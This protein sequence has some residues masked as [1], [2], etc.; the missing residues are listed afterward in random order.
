MLLLL[1]GGLGFALGIVIRIQKDGE[2]YQ[3]TVPASSQTTIDEKGNATVDVT[4]GPGSARPAADET[5]QIET[6][7]IAGA[8]PQTVLSVLT[9]MFTGTPNLRLTVDPKS[10]QLVAMATPAQHAGIRAILE[11]LLPPPGK[12]EA[13]TSTAKKPER[14]QTLVVSP[15]VELKALQGTWNIVRV[16]KGDAAD[17]AWGPFMENYLR[18]G[19]R[20]IF[21]GAAL[22]IR[23]AGQPGYSVYECSVGSNAVPRWIDLYQSVL[24][25]A[26]PFA[27]GVY[28]I[29]GNRL[30]LCLAIKSFRSPR[31]GQRPEELA[32][33]PSSGN[34]LL[35]L[36]R[37]QPSADEEDIQ[38]HWT[39]VTAVEDGETIPEYTGPEFQFSEYDVFNMR[40]VKQNSIA[41]MQGGYILDPGMQPKTITIHTT[42]DGSKSREIFGI[43]KFENDRLHFAYHQGGPRPEKF[44]STRGSGVMLLVLKRIGSAKFTRRAVAPTNP[45]IPTS[46][47][48]VPGAPKA[49]HSA[50]AA[51][52]TVTVS[53]PVVREI[54]DYEDFT[55]R[56]EAAQTVTVRARVTGRLD[57]VVFKPDSMVKQGD[58]LFEIDP[59]P[60]QAEHDKRE[61]DVRLAQLRL[62]RTT[63]E[64]KDAPSPSPSDRRRM[65][66]QQAEAEA[67]LTAA[68]EGLKV[69]R[70][71]LAS[72]R[73]TAP[74]SGKIGRPLIPVGS[75][76]ADPMP[77]ATI[78][79]VD[80]MCVAFD[81]D[82]RTV[83]ALHRHPPPGDGE[84]VPPVLV[85]LADEK[86]FP[87][88]GKVESADT[89]I[90][91][92]TGTAC[93]RALLPNPDGLLMPGMFVRVRLITS[94]PHKALLIPERAIRSDQ[95]QKFVFVV[96][97]RNVIENRAVKL[98]K[99]E[100]ELLIV[101]E[102]ISADDWVVVSGLQGLR[103]GMTVKPEKTAEPP[104]KQPTA[105]SAIDPAAELNALQGQW[106]VLRAV[107][108]TADGYKG[109]MDVGTRLIFHGSFLDILA[110]DKKIDKNTV[111]LSGYRI[112]PRASPKSIDLL[113]FDQGFFHDTGTLGVYEIDGDRLTIC[114]AFSPSALK[115]QRPIRLEIEPG[116]AQVLLTLER[117]RLSEDE[118]TI[119]GDWEVLSQS[120][121]GEPIAEEKYRGTQLTFYEQ[122]VGVTRLPR[123]S[124]FSVNISG[125]FLMDSAEDP[126]RL[127]I[128]SGKRGQPDLLGIYR[129][130]GDRLHI[131]Y[132]FGGPRPKKF[133]SEP[134]R[135]VTSLVLGKS[136]PAAAPQPDKPKAGES[137]APPSP[138]KTPTTTDGKPT[139]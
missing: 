98:G 106:K 137:Q 27:L 114:W 109:G 97:D 18:V 20:F 116:T 87:R 51:P 136:K 74:I 58:L 81:V 129:F 42:G 85:Q 78:D 64:L 19:K 80:P 96:N 76:V 61:A 105:S 77:L 11:K 111:E 135:D 10:N 5:P 47:G 139:N 28:E 13:A 120:V 101:R 65:E 25:G 33:E 6:Y 70:L 60:F 92:A 73:L 7:R 46:G 55:G 84:S 43:Y 52:P 68:Q 88:K 104:P 118:K 138:T 66:A 99:L 75:L 115:P 34:V 14:D 90:D 2:T 44:E 133:E 63:T 16:E 71:N 21:D 82:Q 62:N 9:T 67:A 36:E 132:R 12:S 134:G 113:R 22:K 38:G 48:S 122:R 126:K 112:D 3:L 110:I 123:S 72:T 69:A 91:P 45:A 29:S 107:S 94:A 15:A 59:A 41:F 117:Y 32:V 119:E 35:T 125:L 30:K 8:D 31:T 83:L 124:V 39:V 1:V 79:S 131:A 128:K 89:R 127:T 23:E 17:K 108:G 24:N 130:E 40:T 93:W 26:Q 54:A 121:G 57:K 4:G 53:R 49:G 50:P 103:P 95:D 100:D 56:I 37:Y 86:D 102:G